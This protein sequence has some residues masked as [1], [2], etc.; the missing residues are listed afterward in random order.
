MHS[1][2]PFLFINH[3]IGQ[4]SQ[5]SAVSS[6]TCVEGRLSD[7]QSAVSDVLGFFAASFTISSGTAR[8]LRQSGSGRECWDL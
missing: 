3:C 6:T 7:H 1:F 4:A 5:H 2:E 8:L